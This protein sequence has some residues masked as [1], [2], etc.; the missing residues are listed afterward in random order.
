MS[1]RELASLVLKFQNTSGRPLVEDQASANSFAEL[2]ASHGYG[3]LRESAMSDNEITITI[4]ASEAA[5]RHIESLQATLTKRNAVIE[6][7]TAQLEEA[8]TGEPNQKTMKA[9]YK[10]GWADCA[11]YLV[12]VTAV[13]ANALGKVRKDAYQLYLQSERAGFEES[14]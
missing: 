14:R 12:G 6:R 2:L 8:L 3:K 11:N 9:E 7:L 1:N 4:P 5:G 13:A 10:R